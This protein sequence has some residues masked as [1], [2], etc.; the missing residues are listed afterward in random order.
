[1]LRASRPMGVREGIMGGWL[2]I[3]G[4]AGVTA[5]GLL[6]AIGGMFG[7]LREDRERWRMSQCRMHSWLAGNDPMRCS[8]CG[9]IAGRD[10]LPDR[11]EWG[12]P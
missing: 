6:M 3:A 12:C 9:R 4:A 8:R 2:D 1:M 11:G 10:S 7:L 5:L